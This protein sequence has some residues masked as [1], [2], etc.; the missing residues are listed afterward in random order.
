MSK[1]YIKSLLLVTALLFSSLKPVKIDKDNLFV[2]DALGKI[3]VLHDGTGFSIQKN[4][5][6]HRVKNC[7]VDKEIRNLSSKELM[8]FLGNLKIV[9]INGQKVEFEK[10]TKKQFKKM[11]TAETAQKIEL[12]KIEAEQLFKV[13]SHSHSGYIYVNQMSDGEYS[14]KAHIRVLGGGPITAL[15]SY[16]GVK[17]VS[18]GGIMAVNIATTGPAG[19]AIGIHECITA[20]PTIEVAAAGAE[21]LGLL[22]LTP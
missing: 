14:L 13:L 17:A 16:W 9:E 6:I 19:I 21:T 7:F 5:K 2:P 18:Y 12:D 1:S 20:S 22:A 8:Q 11:A 3:K 15:I 10:I 4:G